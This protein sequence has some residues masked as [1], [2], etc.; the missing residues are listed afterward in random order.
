MTRLHPSSRFWVVVGAI[1]CVGLVLRVVYAVVMVNH[2]P[3]GLDATW[4]SFQAGTIDA[5]TGYV[6]PHTF[7]TTGKAVATANFPPAWPMLLAGVHHLGFASDLAFR[8]TGGLVG[9]TTI[10]TTAAIGRRLLDR[11]VGI[12]SAA[13]VAFSPYLIAADGSLMSESLYLA[14]IGGAVLATI[15]AAERGRLREWCFAGFLFGFACL[16]RSDGVVVAVIV[17]GVAAVRTR[18]PVRRKL[19]VFA[20]ALSTCALVLVPWTVRNSERLGALVLLSSNSGNVIEGANCASTYHGL[21]GAWDFRCVHVVG[22]ADELRSSAEGRR[23]GLAYARHHALRFVA[24]VAP[25]RVLRGWGLWS[26]GAQAD[27]EVVESRNQKFQLFGWVVELGVLAL[28]AAGL[29]VARRTHRDVAVLVAL[30]VAASV[31][32]VVSCGNQRLRL[33]AEPGVAVLAALAL[34][35]WRGR[36]REERTGIL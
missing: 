5:G 34:G 21:V 18:V 13:I 36:R 23:R 15:V 22:G 19:A 30:L 35:E 24:V 17:L 6:D 26:P 27:L 29:V 1:A 28:T 2:A 12:I 20:C 33:V 11:R 4:Y 7:F 32:L 9:T 31:V 8:I 3:L 10:V 25:A 14:L 16:A